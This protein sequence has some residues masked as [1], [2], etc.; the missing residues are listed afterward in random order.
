M[1][2]AQAGDAGRYRA[3]AVVV[4]LAA[5]V[6][7]L[8]ALPGAAAED[9]AAPDGAA[10]LDPVVFVHGALGSASQFESHAMRFTSNGVPQELLFAFEY[11]TIR[12]G[13]EALAEDVA[14]L[15]VFVDEVLAD[16]G[17]DTVSLIGHSRGTGVAHA[18]LDD[19]DRAAKVARYVSLDGRSAEQ[20]PG[21]VPTLA[22]WAA[23]REDPDAVDEREIV[24]ARNVRLASQS[25]SQ[26]ATSAETFAEIFTHLA[27]QAPATVEVL[28]ADEV[29]VAGRAVVLGENRGPTDV[30]L[31]LWEVEAGT[32]QRVGDEPVVAVELPEDGSFGPFD[33]EPGVRYEFAVLQPEGVHHHYLEPF[34]R[35]NHFVRLLVSEPGSL[36]ELVLPSDPEAAA[37]TIQRNR[38][39]WGDQP[40]ADNDSLTVAGTELISP[41]LFPRADWLIGTFVYDDGAD[42]TSNL[43]EPIGLFSLFP[44]IT[45]I[46]LYLPASE[47]GS[48][49]IEVRAIPRQADGRVIDLSVPDRPSEG[50]RTSLQFKD[51][52]EV[53]ADEPPPF[54]DVSP[55]SV[56]AEAIRELQLAGIV[57]GV[58]DERFAPGASIRRDQAASMLARALG[59]DPVDAGPFDDLA[60]NVHAGAVNALAAAGLAEGSEGSFRPSE[61]ITRAQVASLLGRGL[62][63]DPVADGP[64]TDVP[65]E[66]VH[67]P[68]I[69]ALAAIDV[70]R[71]ID[72]TTFAPGRDV[73]RDQFASML[74]RSLEQVG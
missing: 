32:G 6:V 34:E 11:D 52:L 36:V 61:P 9:P 3:G 51:Y 7:G 66:F 13:E 21:G 49:T 31:E 22:V 15:D 30:G 35:S 59:L 73:Q 69:N 19:A 23:P 71:G 64:F 50:H 54:T 62:G 39:W 55:E 58:D 37:L 57:R 14:R 25:H 24:G 56:H 38:E 27:G 41:A 60:G 17:A 65:S 40:L 67:A 47:D 72:A 42:A 4:L 1:I 46:D 8:L 74:A 2:V 33:V 16:T 5:L 45:G 29:S 12:S 48:G 53:A 70:V 26:V 18:Y 43:D 68:M 10:S 28:P 20:P 63:L 44:F